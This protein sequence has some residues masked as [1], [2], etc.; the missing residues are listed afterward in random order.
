MSEITFTVEELAAATKKWH[1]HLYES[2]LTG[3]DKEDIEIINEALQQGEYP[4]KKLMEK[5]GITLSKEELD[6][7]IKKH[8]DSEE[9][10]TDNNTITDDIIE[11]YN[12]GM[13]IEERAEVLDMEET[14]V[15]TILDENEV[16]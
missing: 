15:F 8:L 9:N 12:A 1:E 3:F 7:I 16:L 2:V 4:I 13:N 11:M 10:L 6:G 5:H 14:R